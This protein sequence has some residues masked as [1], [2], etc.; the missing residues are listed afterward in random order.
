M[1][2]RKKYGLGG[3]LLVTLYCVGSE[4]FE[5]RYEAEAKQE[6]LM[7]AGYKP[8]FIEEIEIER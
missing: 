7:I 5:T 1:L 3:G 2:K 4:C 6:A 8:D